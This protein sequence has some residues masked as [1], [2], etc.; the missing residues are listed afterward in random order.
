M[1]NIINNNGND[2]KNTIITIP[3]PTND[4]K[5]SKKVSIPKKL[6]GFFMSLFGIFGS[7]TVLIG[8][9]TVS[10]IMEATIT[11]VQ[12]NS[13]SIDEDYYSQTYTHGSR[14]EDIDEKYPVIKTKTS[15]YKD[16]IVNDLSYDENGVCIQSS[17]SMTV[18]MAD[19]THV[20][21]PNS[22]EYEE[23]YKEYLK[24]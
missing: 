12:N 16:I 11:G 17:T 5:S 7:I 23:I 20:Y 18:K 13:T 22:S 6:I 1:K 19:I 8:T 15:L 14:E 2:N 10:A 9:N 3:P 21:Y 4:K 24:K